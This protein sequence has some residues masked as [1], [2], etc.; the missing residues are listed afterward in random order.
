MFILIPGYFKDCSNAFGDSTHTTIV[1]YIPSNF[2]LN[3]ARLN[4]YSMTYPDGH[5]HSHRSRIQ[6][7]HRP[8]MHP[9]FRWSQQKLHSL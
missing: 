5:S 3:E 4:P 9:F 2:K 6:P 7:V 8:P 1:L